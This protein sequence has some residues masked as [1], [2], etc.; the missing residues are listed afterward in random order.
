M[1][2]YECLRLLHTH[3]PIHTHTGTHLNVIII[4]EDVD[5]LL[6]TPLA[7]I[8]CKNVRIMSDKN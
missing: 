5:P 2:F 7:M 6:H 4:G 1:T 3:T 8:T